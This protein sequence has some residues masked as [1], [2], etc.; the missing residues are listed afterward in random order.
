MK[1]KVIRLLQE[2][3][4]FKLIEELEKDPSIAYSSFLQN[5]T[6][7]L[8]IMEVYF[9]NNESLGFTVKGLKEVIAKTKNTETDRVCTNVFNNASLSVAI[10]TNESFSVLIG[11]I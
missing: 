5:K 1:E 11:I 3:N 7:F 6:D 2:E 8:E 4:Y 10:Y 9:D